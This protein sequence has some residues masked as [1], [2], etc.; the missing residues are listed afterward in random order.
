MKIVRLQAE[1]VKRLRAVSITP[2]GAVVLIKGQNGQGK[3]SLLDSI[4]Y[5][6]GG[7]DV[8]PP[9][10]IREGERSARVVL[11]L[12]DL[13]VERK[14][15]PKSTTLEVRS[16]VGA[17]YG[18][19]QAMLDQLVGKLSFDPLA[20]T[21]MEPKKQVETLR[22]LVGL[23][24]TALDRKRQETF[25]ARTLVNREVVGLKAQLDR[26]PGPNLDPQA[27]VGEE[28]RLSD[29]VQE[30]QRLTGVKQENDRKR[31]AA[32]QKVNA[33]MTLNDRIA[34][35]EKHVEDLRAQ[36]AKSEALLAQLRAEMETAQAEAGKAADEVAALVDPDLAGIT[37][38]L[39]TAESTNAAIRQAKERR[40]LEQKY[41]ARADDAEQLTARI[42]EID[43]EKQK[44]LASAKF[45]V[46]GLSFSEEGITLNGIPLEQAS[47]AEQLRVSLAMGLALNPKLKVVLIRDGSLL[48][49]NSMRLVGEM[50]EATGAQVWV[51][52]VGK[53]GAVGVVIEDG[54]ASGPEAEH[55]GP[56]PEAVA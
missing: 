39:R 46:P 53:G 11:E 27:K 14:W 41:Q 48:D 10:V 16:R 51:E 37:E 13:V 4:A 26:H 20:F 15:T 29:L 1:N 30:Q 8:Q 33:V 36:L 38:R 44:A 54:E 6:L 52:Q 21:R 5:A 19:P 22:Q 7:K 31:R 12:D 49:E 23:D 18:S 50:A 2:E 28:V 24:F 32:D 35:G 55:I 3:T 25:D 43:A 42:A 17:K 34:N 56:A 47:A 9:K 40:L 45:P